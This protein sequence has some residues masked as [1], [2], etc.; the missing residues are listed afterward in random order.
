MPIP[1]KPRVGDVT[2]GRGTAAISM[3]QRSSY[4]LFL[5]SFT[6][7]QATRF[8]LNNVSFRHAVSLDC[9][10]IVQMKPGFAITLE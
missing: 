7:L 4:L 5:S 1:P 6:S 10:I 2:F 3:L 8:G 9:F